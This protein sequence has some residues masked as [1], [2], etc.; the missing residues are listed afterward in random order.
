MSRTHASPVARRGF[1]VR[2]SQ[3]AA[4]TSALLLDSSRLEAASGVAANSGLADPDAW[5]GRLKGE[6]KVMI[7]AH[8]HIMTALVDAGN[9]LANARDMYGVP[10]KQM[11][12]AVITHGP[13]IQGLFRDDVW[14]Q[15]SLG[16]FYKVND[17][18]TNAPATRNIFYKSQEGDLMFPA[19]AVD[20]IQPRGVTFVVCNIAHTVISGML[21]QRAGVP[22]DQ[23]K[24]EFAKGMIPG[25]ILVA[26][27][28]L[29]VNRAQE[30]GKCTYCY[31]G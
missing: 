14:Q 11:S 16:A 22:A 17:P 6:Q 12:I 1:L 8:Q 3:A 26:S 25:F 19:M 30:K 28:V 24:A 18:K 27:G 23:A 2:L 20:K 4:A 5:I 31:A 29:A 13:A 15:K 21:G 10:E 7:H 9:M